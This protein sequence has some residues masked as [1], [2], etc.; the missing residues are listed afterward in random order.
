MT[1]GSTGHCE[2]MADMFVLLMAGI[3]VLNEW[4]GWSEE[5]NRR[6]AEVDR[7]RRRETKVVC[8]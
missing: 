5:M 8:M 4:K 6:E 7:R 2:D 1:T 3:G